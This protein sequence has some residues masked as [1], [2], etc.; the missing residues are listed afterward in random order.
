M[1]VKPTLAAVAPRIQSNSVA[2]IPAVDLLS[3]V[4]NSTRGANIAI[5]GE[6]GYGKS[7][8]LAHFA[9]IFHDRDDLQM[10]DSHKRST[11]TNPRGRVQL[12]ACRSQS[13]ALDLNADCWMLAEWGLDEALE[14]LMSCHRSDCGRLMPM[15]YAHAS[16][17]LL[18]RRPVLWRK[19]LELLADDAS[20]ATIQQGIDSIVKSLAS[21]PVADAASVGPNS[22]NTRNAISRDIL[23]PFAKAILLDQ[24]D[25]RVKAVEPLFDQFKSKSSEQD[26]AMKAL[27]L[28]SEEA[29]YVPFALNGFV[30]ELIQQSTP[31]FL[32]NSVTNKLNNRAIELVARRVSNAPSLLKKL[33][34]LIA[35]VSQCP[36]MAASVLC[37]AVPNWRPEC[38]LAFL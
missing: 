33:S 4:L 16:S 35:N 36:S 10:W 30:E 22:H 37:R 2:S 28:I 19:L 3:D 5:C 25:L 29:I 14:Y 26:F 8:A 12:F 6:K 23:M 31:K 9:A 21:F 13:E 34:D 1:N 17:G 20:I 24:D 18:P 11:A 38:P 27:D 32:V 15:L 7:A